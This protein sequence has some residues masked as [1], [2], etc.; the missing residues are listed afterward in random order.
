MLVTRSRETDAHNQTTP[1]LVERFHALRDLDTYGSRMWQN[2]ESVPNLYDSPEVLASYFQE[3]VTA[4]H[5]IY[6]AERFRAALRTPDLAA[7]HKY[8]KEV[9]KYALILKTAFQFFHAE[10]AAP[11]ALKQFTK[12]LGQYN[13]WYEHPDQAQHTQHLLPDTLIREVEA[14]D[15]TARPPSLEGF[16]KRLRD[17]IAEVRQLTAHTELPTPEFHDA[18]KAIRTLMNVLQVPASHEL[19]S[20][21]HHLFLILHSFSKQLGDQHDVIV[22]DTLGNHEQYNETITQLPTE[23]QRQL[24]TVLRVIEHS[25]LTS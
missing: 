10:L 23:I 20:P 6:D 4:W 22:S 17:K 9:R 3:A 7:S 11:A 12:E 1:E 15:V 8:L 25:T 16:H 21:A 13:D 24:E 14:L 18:R 2:L 5:H 19:D